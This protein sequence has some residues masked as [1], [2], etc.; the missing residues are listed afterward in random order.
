LADGGGY[1]FDA[2]ATSARRERIVALK[3]KLCGK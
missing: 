1:V 3:H 2:E